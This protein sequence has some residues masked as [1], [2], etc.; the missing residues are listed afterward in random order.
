M[1]HTVVQEEVLYCVRMR[2]HIFLYKCV[3]PASPNLKSG[4]AIAVLRLS[5]ALNECTLRIPLV[6]HAPV[7]SGR[8]RL[9]LKVTAALCSLTELISYAHLPE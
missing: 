1:A 6:C 3:I 8:G 9:V 2:M 5:R 4:Q 7:S